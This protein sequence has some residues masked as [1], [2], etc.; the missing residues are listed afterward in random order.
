MSTVRAPRRQSPA[1][2][3][4]QARQRRR[5][6]LL[7]VPS[8]SLPPSSHVRDPTPLRCCQRPPGAVMLALRSASPTLSACS[9]PSVL[10]SEEHTSELQSLMR[11]SYAVFCLNTKKH[12]KQ[13]TSRHNYYKQNISK[14]T[15]KT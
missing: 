6:P 5:C 11:I 7:S 2:V 10:R 13:H 8:S 1:T 4:W 3:R 15:V 9:R 14:R 12:V